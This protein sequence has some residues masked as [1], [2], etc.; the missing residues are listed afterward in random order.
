VSR[1]RKK[2]IYLQLCM[3]YKRKIKKTKLQF[4]YGILKKT[5]ILCLQTLKNEEITEKS[6]KKDQQKANKAIY[7]GFFGYFLLFSANQLRNN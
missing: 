5:L 6:K 4:L 3:L 7:C 1:I 2:T